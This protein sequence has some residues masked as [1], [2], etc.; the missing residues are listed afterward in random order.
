[1]VTCVAKREN[2]GS[3]EGNPI[4]DRSLTLQTN[5]K[6]SLF[7]VSWRR[8]GAGEFPEW[9]RV[10]VGR[11]M[12]QPAST[13]PAAPRRKPRRTQFEDLSCRRVLEDGPF[14]LSENS[15]W[16]C[17]LSQ[18]ARSL[19]AACLR[20]ARSGHRKKSLRCYATDAAIRMLR[21]RLPVA[22]RFPVWHPIRVA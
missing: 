21:F 10:G 11:A 17:W 12:R 16:I 9:V 4:R 18:I 13:L 14:T 2:C 7:G 20:H 1:M 19:P 22:L 6:L 8:D 3:R 5:P 15:P